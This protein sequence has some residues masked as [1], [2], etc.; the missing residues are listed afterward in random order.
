MLFYV[1]KG[2]FKYLLLFNYKLLDRFRKRYC[3]YCGVGRGD[4]NLHRFSMVAA[5]NKGNGTLAISIVGIRT[6]DINTSRITSLII[7]TCL[8]Y[9]TL[10]NVPQDQTCV[11]YAD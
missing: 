7:R 11:T 6:L 8:S 2:G 10:P 3:S 5:L 9:F 1:R 4:S